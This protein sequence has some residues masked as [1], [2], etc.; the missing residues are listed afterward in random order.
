MCSCIINRLTIYMHLKYIRTTLSIQI[1]RPK[2]VSLDL[3]RITAPKWLSSKSKEMF[4]PSCE[5]LSEMVSR[6]HTNAR[7]ASCRPKKSFYTLDFCLFALMISL[8]VATND[9][10]FLT[11]V[12][13]E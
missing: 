6:A 7:P 4:S 8:M 3:V 11:F 2:T 10:S 5:L 13:F 1:W 12:N 9:L